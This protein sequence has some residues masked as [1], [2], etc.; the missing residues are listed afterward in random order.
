M[1]N[2]V[3]VKVTPDEDKDTAT[4]KFM[5]RPTVRAAMTLQQ[6]GNTESKMDL[7]GLIVGLTEQTNQVIG[8]DLGRAEA[9][10]T[11]QAHTLDAIFNK[12]AQQ[13]ALNMCEYV[14]ACDIYLKLALRAQSQC[15]STW[16]A[17]SAIK[18]PPQATFVKQANIAHGHQQVNNAPASE[19]SRTRTENKKTQNELL[20]K[21]DGERLDTRKASTASTVNSSVGTLV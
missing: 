14:G 7:M 21:T 13:A 5:L 2:E 9:M 3:T 10:L 18:N 19:T 11:A 12:L 20:E 8:N 4:A 15:R 6:Y 16:E 1:S 17:V